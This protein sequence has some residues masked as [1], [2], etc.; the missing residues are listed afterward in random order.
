MTPS[1]T[2]RSHTIS[3]LDLFGQVPHSSAHAAE[4]AQAFEALLNRVTAPTKA[5]PHRQATQRASAESRG[6]KEPENRVE[7]TAERD[8]DA[9]RKKQAD[10]AGA[11][12]EARRKNATQEPSDEPIHEQ[13]TCSP[14]GESSAACPQAPA[15]PEGQVILAEEGKQLADLAIDQ[16]LVDQVV[17]TENAPANGVQPLVPIVDQMLGPPLPSTETG[18]PQPVVIS[19][20]TDNPSAPA[21]Q[22]ALIPQEPVVEGLAV[23][24]SPEDEARLP[25]NGLFPLAETEPDSAPTAEPVALVDEPAA[26]VDIQPA[27]PTGHDADKEQDNSRENDRPP[28][29][30]T[31]H[32]PSPLPGPDGPA[33]QEAQTTAA[34][35]PPLPAH[36][37]SS[38]KDE[39]RSPTGV[40]ETT[41]GAQPSPSR[42]PQHVLNRTEI[43]RGHNPAPVPVDSTR[44]LNRVAKAFLS[45]QQRDGNEVRLRLSPPELGSLRLQVSVQD[46]VMVARLET[47][48]EAAR[49]SLVNNLPALRER[50]AEQG[51][52]VERFDIELM[53]RPSTGTPDRPNDPQQQ[54][55]PQPLRLSRTSS[56]KSEVPTSA[57]PTSNWNGQGRLNVI[58]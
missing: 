39:T 49:S 14:T 12:R 41:S 3:P 42:L 20:P 57:A 6:T 47:E 37:P 7:Q 44:F 26:S 19:L 17:P 22:P 33:T 38:P 10:K 32:S 9:V 24:P 43:H 28:R 30:V 8:V 53:Q 25:E 5:P 11:S 31:D 4:P 16:V 18:E 2:D 48:T 51:I 34:T 55:D 56:S 27:E 29:E 52:R 21:N 46:G 35:P 13:T 15:A 50:L 58:I 36:A 40:S 1:T 23:N 45:A 54:P